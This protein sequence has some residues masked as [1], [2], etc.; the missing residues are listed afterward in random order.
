M[1]SVETFHIFLSE[2]ML[3]P[4]VLVQWPLSG[5]VK[6]VCEEIVWKVSRLEM[7]MLTVL[8]I[9]TRVT[10][11]VITMTRNTFQNKNKDFHNNSDH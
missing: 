2:S 6:S 11:L 8:V 5:L 4:C 1:F 10:S 3:L 7:M 9:V